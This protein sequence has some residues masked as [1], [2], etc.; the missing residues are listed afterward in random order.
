MD[1]EY[2]DAGGL[3]QQDKDA[4]WDATVSDN[5]EGRRRDPIRVILL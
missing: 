4:G 5:K 1:A 2:D 3:F